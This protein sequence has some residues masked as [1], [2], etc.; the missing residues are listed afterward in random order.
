M[1]G[2]SCESLNEHARGL[3]TRELSPRCVALADYSALRSITTSNPRERQTSVARFII[4]EVDDLGREAIFEL[5]TP[6][7]A[8]QMPLAPRNKARTSG[9][10]LGMAVSPRR[11]GAIIALASAL[12]DGPHRRRDRGHC[13]VVLRFAGPG[14]S[15]A[16]LE[17]TSP[18]GR[19]PRTI[20][21]LK[22][23]GSRYSLRVRMLT[24]PPSHCRVRPKYG[25]NA[26]PDIHR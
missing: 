5:A 8:L 10:D 9:G 23:A 25:G 6:I 13:I 11:F 26:V 14:G 19:C 7:K 15:K 1:S 18:S 2:W 4:A 21:S 12:I 16:A 22:H 3:S 17:A 24:A 20:A